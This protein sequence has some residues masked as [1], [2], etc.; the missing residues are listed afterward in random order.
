M[1]GGERIGLMIRRLREER[2][3]SQ[4]DLARKL[5]VD[6]EALERATAAGKPGWSRWDHDRPVM[7]FAADGGR[8]VHAPREEE[9]RLG[10]D[11]GAAEG[12]SPLTRK[13]TFLRSRAPR[14]T[15]SGGGCIRHGPPD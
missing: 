1:A 9:W 5:D 15:T 8:V 6:A 13:G 3:L 12:I 7:T 14:R 10:G 2:G 4:A 11:C